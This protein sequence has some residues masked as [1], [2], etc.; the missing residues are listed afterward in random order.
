MALGVISFTISV[1]CLAWID[2]TIWQ[3]FWSPP[4]L[5][6]ML[7]T[8]SSFSLFLYFSSFIAINIDMERKLKANNSIC[9]CHTMI[10]YVTLLRH[11]T[12]QNPIKSSTAKYT[13]DS[14]TLVVMHQLGYRSFAQLNYS[15]K[16]K[17]SGTYTRI[18]RPKHLRYPPPLL[19]Q[20]HSI[21]ILKEINGYT[22]LFFIL[23]TEMCEVRILDGVGFFLLFSPV[24]VFNVR[25]LF[26]RFCWRMNQLRCAFLNWRV[27]AMNERVS[28]LISE[29]MSEWIDFNSWRVFKLW[30]KLKNLSWKST[31]VEN[32]RL[33]ESTR[34]I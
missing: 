3:T 34:L 19:H 10:C 31:S 22:F 25:S 29:R 20:Q 8:S 27:R 30:R 15:V 17:H 12:L 6:P 14:F 2:T 16:G 26:C 32:N 4:M 7:S 11:G 28:E 1:N 9:W 5:L 24:S 33:N 21:I 18:H 23:S 13:F